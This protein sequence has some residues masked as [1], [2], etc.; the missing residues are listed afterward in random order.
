M[1]RPLPLKSLKFPI[2][3]FNQNLVL[4]EENESDLSSC[5]A[6]ALKNGWF[7]K[8]IIIDSE[9]KYVSVAYA[10]KLCGIGPFWGYRIFRTQ[11]IK[12]ELFIKEEPKKVQVNCVKGK[13]FQS[14][15]KWHGWSS[16]DDFDELNRRM[17]EAQSF[18]EIIQIL[19]GPVLVVSGRSKGTISGRNVVPFG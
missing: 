17:Q 18:Q 15:K 5:G 19:K 4:I 13:V 3:C 11:R 14:F 6:G 9:M 10:K 16:R 1:I 12:I 8:M 7:E 2:L